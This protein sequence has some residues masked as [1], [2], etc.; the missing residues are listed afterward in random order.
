VLSVTL[1]HPA[2]AI[3]QNEMLFGRDI[4]VVP[5]NTLLDGAL[6]PSQEGEIW[7]LER[8]RLMPNVVT[9]ESQDVMCLH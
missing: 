8:Y 4:C 1:V 7:G 9:S 6:V 3:G 5:G 2:K